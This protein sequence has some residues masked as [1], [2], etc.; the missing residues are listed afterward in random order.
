MNNFRFSKQLGLTLL[1]G[2]LCFVQL[3]AMQAGSVPGGWSPAAADDERV[4]LAAEFAFRNAFLSNHNADRPNGIT[5][6]LVRAQQQVVAGM[7]YALT[8]NVRIGEECQVMRF[9]LKPVFFWLISP[10]PSNTGTLL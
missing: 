2:L 5:W 1:L 10:F 4:Q 3:H 6:S 9:S 7:N 8:M